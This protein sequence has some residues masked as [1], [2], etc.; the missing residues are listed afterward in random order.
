MRRCRGMPSAIGLKSDL[1]HRAPSPTGCYFPSAEGHDG[2]AGR[3]GWWRRCQ[4]PNQNPTT[5]PRRGTPPPMK[6]GITAKPRCHQWRNKHNPRSPH[7]SLADRKQVLTRRA[8]DSPPLGWC[9]STAGHR[10]ARRAFAGCCL[11]AHPS[12][13]QSGRG[14]AQGLVRRALLCSPLGLP[15]APTPAGY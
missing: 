14:C 9:V 11:N 7:P 6:R 13:G 10:G 8:T 15:A 5:P 4:S 3:G 2:A 12:S 1:P